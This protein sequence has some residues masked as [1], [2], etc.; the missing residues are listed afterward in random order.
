MTSG[1]SAPPSP[2]ADERVMSISRSEFETSIAMLGAHRDGENNSKFFDLP[3]GSVEIAF[4]ALPSV[5]LGGLLALPRAK[6]TLKF[7]ETVTPAGR[8]K[9]V[10]LF[11]TS[12][13][14]GGG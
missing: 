10:L 11:D 5:T 4:T 9:F 6:L 7:S 3:S 14:R 1:F 8:A 12:F 2:F 13:Q